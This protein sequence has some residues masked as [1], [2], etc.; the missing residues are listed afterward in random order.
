MGAAGGAVQPMVWCVDDD[1]SDKSVIEDS[2]D[3]TEDQSVLA[4]APGEKAGLR[5]GGGRMFYEH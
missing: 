2:G 3:N 4:E 1:A 5:P